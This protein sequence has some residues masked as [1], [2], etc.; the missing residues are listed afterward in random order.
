MTKNVQLT[1]IQFGQEHNTGVLSYIN[2]QGV[3]Y[4]VRFATKGKTG[5]NA[6][7]GKSAH[8]DWDSI[9]IYKQNRFQA[10]TQQLAQRLG[11]GRPE[12]YIL[13]AEDK[14]YVNTICNQIKAYK[15]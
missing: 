4:I 11:F 15:I 3:G 6:V 10:K 8:I 7:L 13:G 5:T 2:D 14:E 9:S 1:K 12:N